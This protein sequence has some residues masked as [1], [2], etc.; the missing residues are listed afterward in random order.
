M[1]LL[2]EQLEEAGQLKAGFLGFNKSGKTYTGIS[3]AIALHQYIGSTKPIAFYDTEKG[4]EYVRDLIVKGTQKNPIVCKSRSLADLSGVLNE[5]IAGASDIL[6]VDSITHPWR[7]CCDSYMAQI[8]KNLLAKGKRPR[9]R[10]EFQDW[11][12][13]K[14]KWNTIW[15]TPFVNAPI[16]IIICGRA[17]DTYAYIEND[18]GDKE[19]TKTGVKMKTESEFGFE[20]SLLVEMVR[21]QEI[22]DGKRKVYHRATVIGD[23]F[24]VIDG[25]STVDP[26]PEFFMPHI[27]ML[28]LK[29][30]S[31]IDAGLKTEF[32]ISEEGDAEFVARRKAK[33]S[34][35]EEIWGTF[36]KLGLGTGAKDK[37]IKVD[38][39]DKIFR[40]K[41]KTAIE[42]MNIDQLQDAYNRLIEDET[43]I[44]LN[45]VATADIK[46]T[47]EEAATE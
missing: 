4:S 43:V 15:A 13:I 20:P 22:I 35:L 37:Q 6:F 25:N 8:N 17:G 42:G 47:V 30:Y 41:S 1:S 40:T 12:P 7:E 18:N 9:N 16:H 23:R 33:E 38:L 28:N 3:L 36:D 19:L 39:L 11:L 29:A 44:K 32:G 21:E 10:I 26:A 5:C 27:K 2:K 31:Q 24:H 45:K 46:R 34:L 14:D